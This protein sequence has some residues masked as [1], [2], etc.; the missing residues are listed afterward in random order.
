MI[1]FEIFFKGMVFYFGFV[2]INVNVGEIFDLLM[3]IIN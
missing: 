3:V 2:V 1:N